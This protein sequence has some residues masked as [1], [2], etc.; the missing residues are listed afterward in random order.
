MSDISPLDIEHALT[1]Q[2]DE[3]HSYP[4]TE[5]E[6]GNITGYGHQ[7]RATF[8]EA[9]NEY[10]RLTDT[11]N[12]PEIYNLTEEDVFHLWAVLDESDGDP[13]YRQATEDTPGAIPVTAIW[14][15][16]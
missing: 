12:E 11:F 10:D 15:V 4:F 16:R 7:D 3:T 14:G 13:F 9:V 2:Y 5:D 8:A 6:H 1:M